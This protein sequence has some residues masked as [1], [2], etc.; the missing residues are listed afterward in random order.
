M[1]IVFIVYILYTT[2]MQNTQDKLM[3]EPGQPTAHASK[4]FAC[5]HFQGS[6]NL[7]CKC[8]QTHRPAERSIHAILT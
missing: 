2:Y 6:G 4:P 1:Y 5:C 3:F 7:E 8:L